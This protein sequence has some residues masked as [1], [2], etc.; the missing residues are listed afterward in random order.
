[1]RSGISCSF[2]QHTPLLPLCS[3]HLARRVLQLEKVNASLRSQVKA[4]E[5]KTSELKGELATSRELVES[6][7]QPSGYLMKRVMEQ[8]SQLQQGKERI[9]QL[10]GQLASVKR[11]KSLLVETKNQMAADLERLLNHREVHSL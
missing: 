10:E 1:M 5:V 3:V 11:E 2:T 4:E 7:Q 9:A 6:S 8:S